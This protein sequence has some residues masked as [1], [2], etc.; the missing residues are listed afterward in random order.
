MSTNIHR[1]LG[2]ISAQWKT[3]DRGKIGHAVQEERWPVPRTNGYLGCG[4]ALKYSWPTKYPHARKPPANKGAVMAKSTKTK[5]REWTK[6]DVRELKTLA[7]QKTPVAK[8]AKSLKRTPGA[9]QQKAFTLG[10]S[11]D[12]RG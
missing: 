2:R 5:R 8:I 1:F 11:L 6:D 7:R 12:S 10:V 9:T 4:V 3:V